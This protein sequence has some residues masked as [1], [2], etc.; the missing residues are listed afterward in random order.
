M[1][2]PVTIERIDRALDTLAVIIELFGD[3][4]LPIFERLERER[5]EL[6]NSMQTRKRVRERATR[7]LA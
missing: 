6:Q 3:A 5:A 1:S 4:Y 2:K 7:H